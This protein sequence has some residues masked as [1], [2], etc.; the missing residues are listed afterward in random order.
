MDKMIGKRIAQARKAKQLSQEKLAELS[1]L[2]VSAI[3]RI[4]TGHN[5][6]SLKTLKKLC[7]ILDVSLGY[8]LYDLLPEQQQLQSPVVARSC[9]RA[10]G[11]FTH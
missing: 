6:T 10:L 8:L 11:T 9:L 2:S 5:S 4:E 1:E 3:S 7:S